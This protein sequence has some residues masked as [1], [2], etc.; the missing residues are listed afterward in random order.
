VCH[1]CSGPL[2]AN[3]K[4]AIFAVGL[5]GHYSAHSLCAPCWKD[6]Q[7]RG[8]PGINVTTKA[9]GNAAAA[10]QK[11]DTGPLVPGTWGNW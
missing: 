5:S 4:H 10:K 1:E 3:P 11:R 9:R 7:D 2:G 8:G 6:A